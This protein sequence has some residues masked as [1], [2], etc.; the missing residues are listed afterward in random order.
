MCFFVNI[1]V[2]DKKVVLE[3]SLVGCLKVTTPLP[4]PLQTKTRNGCLINEIIS[5]TRYVW[6]WKRSHVDHHELSELVQLT[7]ALGAISFASASDKLRF[8][9]LGDGMY[10]VGAMRKGQDII[11]WIITVPLKVLCL[12]WT[13]ALGR[14]LAEGER[15]DTAHHLLLGCQRAKTTLEW[16]LKWCNIPYR[17]FNDVSGFINF[18]A[19]WGNS[20]YKRYIL[21]TIFYCV[22]WCIWKA[23]NGLP[24]ENHKIHPLTFYPLA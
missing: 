23:R 19:S 17:E 22:L 16:I 21:F 24:F 13:T 11:K 7:S 12:N 15:E 4:P 3:G 8:I 9:P 10:R 1:W 5:S 18:A 20:P 6:S 2:G 14:I